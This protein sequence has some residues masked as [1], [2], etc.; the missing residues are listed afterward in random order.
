MSKRK[1][2][3]VFEEESGSLTTVTL[4]DMESPFLIEFITEMEDKGSHLVDHKHRELSGLPVWVFPF[5]L[6]VAVCHIVW[7]LVNW[8]LQ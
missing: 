7:T 5:S 4:F 1:D 2:I 8:Y 6:G 3:L